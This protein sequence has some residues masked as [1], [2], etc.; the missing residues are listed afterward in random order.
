LVL[1][2][3]VALRHWRVSIQEKLDTLVNDNQKILRENDLLW[4]SLQQHALTQRALQHK[5]QKVLY[6]MYD[7]YLSSGGNHQE[8]LPE[9]GQNL[10]SNGNQSLF[11]QTRGAIDR[12][13]LRGRGLSG[14]KDA[15]FLE[16][17][18][19]LGLEA[20]VSPF[21]GATNSNSFQS[22]MQNAQAYSSALATSSR[23]TQSQMNTQ[24]AP[25]TFCAPISKPT[26]LNWPSHDLIPETI[27]TDADDE[28]LRK[29]AMREQETRE[30][31]S[32]IEDSLSKLFE[33]EDFCQLVMNH[34]SF[35]P[36]M[37]DQV[38]SKLS[39]AASERQKA[40]QLQHQAPHQLFPTGLGAPAKM[41]VPFSEPKLG[42]DLLLGLKARQG[43]GQQ[44]LPV[45]GDFC[46]G[47]PLY[48]APQY[49]IESNHQNQSLALAGSQVPQSMMA[50]PTPAEDLFGLFD[51]PV[52]MNSKR[53][54][55][56]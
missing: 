55:W 15:E 18:K 50:S 19:I 52:I 56:G 32:K 35:S 17:L 47:T 12:D 44:F 51:D 21:E 30:K 11:G 41:N 46:L 10:F 29:L 14:L 22:F 40:A 48:S 36:V 28:S 25:S 5:M 1:S 37:E 49:P 34:P 39:T 13:Q 26:S 54:T 6:F 31:I 43:L 38:I 23:P 9:S 53:K 2:E 3:L 24:E 16:K 7:M 4:Q 20:P 27:P 45:S 8:I 42:A 33:A